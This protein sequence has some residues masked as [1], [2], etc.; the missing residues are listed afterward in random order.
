MTDK[1]YLE[2]ILE[3]Q[4]L[5]QDS[6]ELQE[7]QEKRDE[8]EELLRAEFEESNPTIRYGGSKA[9][10]T[11]IR[12]SYDLDIICYFEHEDDDG[13]ETLKEIYD[14]V[15]NALQKKYIVNPKTSALRLISSDTQS[16]GDPL[17]IDVV[18]GR[19]TDDKKEN[20]F[21]YYAGAEKNR[22][23]TNLQTH[24][25]HVKNSG[26]RDVIKLMK[27]W[28]SKRDIDIKTFVLELLIIEVLKDFKG[29]IDKKLLHLWQELK[30]NLDDYSIEDPANS[31]NDLSDIYNDSKK[32][33]LSNAAIS[34]LFD[35]DKFGWESVFGST[36]AKSKLERIAIIERIGESISNPAKPY[37]FIIKNEKDF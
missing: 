28:K 2:A 6:D 15:L 32:I 27:L 24:I 1:E 16:E 7:L 29:S 35:I 21:L 3:D 34:T 25:D 33:A 8:V 11:M 4:K 19:F 37:G 14:N 22:L 18:P 5:S 31:N 12:D 20:A 36:D 10:G 13:G 17:H 23:K 9:K 30:D 26:L